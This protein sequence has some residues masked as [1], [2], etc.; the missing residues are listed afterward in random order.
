[1]RTTLYKL[2]LLAA[3]ATFTGVFFINWCHL[4]YDCGCTFMWAG[5]ADHCNIQTAGPPDCPWCARADLAGIAFFATIGA[6]AAVS[7]WPGGVGWK[8]IL[9]AFV[10]SPAVAG[11]TGL[12]IGLQTGYWG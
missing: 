6:Q 7:L 2:L 11:A 3:A 1:M 5:A 8:R 12:V 10:A 9:A 4:V